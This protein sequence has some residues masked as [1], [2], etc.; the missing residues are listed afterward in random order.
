MLLF[1]DDSFHHRHTSSSRSSAETGNHLFGTR[2]SGREIKEGARTLRFAKANVK[3]GFPPE[4]VLLFEVSAW[5]ARRACFMGKDTF[6]GYDQTP[7]P[8]R[9]LEDFLP[10]PAFIGGDEDFPAGFQNME[11]TAHERHANPT[12]VRRFRFRIRIE[13]KATF[14]R[15]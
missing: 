6:F 11:Q 8:S 12:F 1:L 3:A 7:V 2:I 13:N 4:Q 15:R 5:Q 14:N 10:V 9:E